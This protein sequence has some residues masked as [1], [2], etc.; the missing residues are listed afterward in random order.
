MVGQDWSGFE[1]AKK[2]DQLGL[3][4]FIRLEVI[5]GKRKILVQS[6]TRFSYWLPNRNPELCLYAHSF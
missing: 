2:L 6:Y 5:K 4:S 1:F 3:S